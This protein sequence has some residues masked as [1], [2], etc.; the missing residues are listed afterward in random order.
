MDYAA[1]MP[2]NLL[3]ERIM[4]HSAGMCQWGLGALLTPFA[5]EGGIE[6][7]PPQE[8]ADLA[9]LGASV[10]FV[11]DALFV[12]SIEA[13]MFGFRSYFGIRNGRHSL[14]IPTRIQ[15]FIR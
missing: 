8:R 5:Q 12:F 6:T 11:Q 1:S 15:S 9:R 7:L 10:R 4:G 14:A 13:A 3:P 2:S